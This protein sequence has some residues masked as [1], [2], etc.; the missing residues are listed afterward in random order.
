MP[1]LV[2]DEAHL[3]SNDQLEALW[4]LTNVGMDTESK[5][6]LLLL[7]RLTF[8]R[9]MKLAVLSALDQR[10]GTRY[11]LEGM[12]IG[13]LKDYLGKHLGFAGRSDTLFLR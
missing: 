9:R 11:T 5:F 12:G 13:D 8:P 1:T 4:M 2:I 10:V 7:G 3:L 6:E